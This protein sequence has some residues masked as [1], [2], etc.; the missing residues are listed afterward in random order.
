MDV[1]VNPTRRKRNGNLGKL[2]SNITINIIIEIDILGK[3]DL[4]KLEIVITNT[5]EKI[6]MISIG[7][8]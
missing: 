6:I 7:I 8:V 2:I 4:I 3:G 5:V 1:I